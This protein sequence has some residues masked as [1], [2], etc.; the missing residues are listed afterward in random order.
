MKLRIHVKYVR[1]WHAGQV[2]VV[3]GAKSAGMALEDCVQQREQDL[4]P[5]HP[6]FILRV[7][8]RPT[9]TKSWKEMELAPAGPLGKSRPELEGK[10]CRQQQ[11][12][13]LSLLLAP[14]LF[15]HGDPQSLALGT[16]SITS[17]FPKTRFWSL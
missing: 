13:Y 10:R 16:E 3:E 9:T 12:Q 7:I 6:C 11:A 1:E 17:H 5:S 15:S 4:L 14:L 2:E 8:P